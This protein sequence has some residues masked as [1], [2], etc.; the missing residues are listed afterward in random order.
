MQK[1]WAITWNNYYMINFNHI[2]FSKTEWLITVFLLDL[3]SVCL[4]VCPSIHP[5]VSL[6]FWGGPPTSMRHFFSASVRPSRTISQELYIYGHNFWYTCVKW[7]YLQAF[8]LF[9]KILIFWVFRGVK[10]QKIT[11][12]TRQNDYMSRMFFPFF[13]NFDFSGVRRVKGQKTVQSGKKLWL[14]RS[15]SQEPCIL[16]MSFKVHMCKMIISL[17]VSFIF[18]KFWFCELLLG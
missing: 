5:S 13:Q 12:A 16:Y 7:G 8:F 3:L 17:D 2:R 10:G 11:Y 6:A 18:K 1:E 15:I 4:S 9:F 14:L